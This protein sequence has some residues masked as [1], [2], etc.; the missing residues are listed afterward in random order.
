MLTCAWSSRIDLWPKQFNVFLT[1]QSCRLSDIHA[2]LRTHGT[3]L[4]MF[5][6]DRH[7]NATVTQNNDANFRQLARTMMTHQVVS[8]VV[9]D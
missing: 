4:C 9:Y 2:W 5:M 3:P 8:L 7:G 6:P 1:R